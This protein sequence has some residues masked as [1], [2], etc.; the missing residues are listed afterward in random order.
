MTTLI[1]VVFNL[2]FDVNT[3][4]AWA[5]LW[6]RAFHL[7]VLNLSFVV[8]KLN[9]DMH[10][11]SPPY[12]AREWAWTLSRV[13][14]DVLQHHCTWDMTHF[15]CETELMHVRSMMH[16]RVRYDS[17]TCETWL[18]HMWDTTHS[19]WDIFSSR[20][21][22]DA[23]TCEIW[24]IHTWE[25][26]RIYSHVRRCGK[27]PTSSWLLICFL[28]PSSCMCAMTHSHVRRKSFISSTRIIHLWDMTHSHVKHDSFTCETWLIHLWNMTQSRVRHDSFTC[29]T[30][31]IHMWNMTHSP[32]RH[33]SFTCITCLI[34]L[35]DMTHSQ[36]RHDSFACMIWLIHMWDMTL[37]IAHQ[38][39][40]DSWWVSNL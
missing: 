39:F 2:C 4:N 13:R 12:T 22:H 37:E 10:G 29:M 17:F 1:S 23:F 9:P 3:L 28:H 24:L 31:P 8:T 21:R 35:A 19:M 25:M 36:V 32:V 33:D 40:R 5:Y 30:R 20:E 34:H 16:S 18:I 6:R 7:F 14:H 11:G 26:T 38:Q 15:K 27:I